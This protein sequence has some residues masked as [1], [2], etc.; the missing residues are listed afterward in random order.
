MDMYYEF[1]HNMQYANIYMCVCVCACLC[2]FF[3]LKSGEKF[4]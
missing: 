4:I 1:M 3:S 2:G